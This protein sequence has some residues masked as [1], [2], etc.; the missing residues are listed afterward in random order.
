M[1]EEEVLE[2]ARQAIWV[3]IKVGAP[4]M[5]IALVVGLIV[6]LLQALTQIQEM[7]LTFVPK[8]LAMMVGFIV[9]MPFMLN[10]LSGFTTGLFHQIASMGP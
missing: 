2:V 7:T 3:T 5:L 8:I 4:T 6:S 1:S 10:V 9:A